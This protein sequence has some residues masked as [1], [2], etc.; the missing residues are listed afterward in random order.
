MLCLAFAGSALAK[1]IRIM[2]REGWTEPTNIFGVVALP[3]G[4]RKSAVLADS[5]IPVQI[6]ESEEQQRMA[7]LIAEA[8]SEH[9]MLEIRVKEAEKKASKAEDAGDREQLAAEARALA[10][11]LDAHVVPD[12]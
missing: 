11:E 1:K 3:P 6:H 2:I 10:K 8:A 12:P 7:P 5:L 9:R 4:D